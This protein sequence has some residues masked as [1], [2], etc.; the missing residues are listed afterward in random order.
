[1]FVIRL[2]DSD[3]LFNAI[4]SRMF[5]NYPMYIV[6]PVKINYTIKIYD[7]VLYISLRDR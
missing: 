1:M 6:W 2:I 3:Y 5:E 4:K 7:L